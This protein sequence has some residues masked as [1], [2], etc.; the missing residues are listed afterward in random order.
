ME[1]L[2]AILSSIVII[3]ITSAFL[4]YLNLSRI[5]MMK[6]LLARQSALLTKMQTAIKTKNATDSISENAE[7]VY[8]DLLSHISPIIRAAE[9]RIRDNE[10]HSLWRALGGLVDEYSRNPY[11]LENLRRLIK[12][13]SDISRSTD[14]FLMRSEKLLRHL[15]ANDPDGMLASVFADGLLGQTM[16][17]LSQAKQLAN[18]C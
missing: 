13:D 16:S 2:Y 9:I 4:T 10:Q 3:T 14:A 5:R 17:L 1:I 7:I 6:Q 18:N 12:L 15:A 8:Q 11:V